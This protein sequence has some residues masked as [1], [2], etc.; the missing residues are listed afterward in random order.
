[1]PTSLAILPAHLSLSA[2]LYSRPDPSIQG[3]CKEDKH[4]FAGGLNQGLQPKSG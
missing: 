3:F 1:M 2:F 4:L